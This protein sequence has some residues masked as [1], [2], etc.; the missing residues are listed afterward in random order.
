MTFL[1]KA[2]T[3]W[4][5]V[6][7]SNFNDIVLALHSDSISDKLY[8]GGSFKFYDQQI[9]KGVAFWNGNDVLN[10][11]C[12][13]GGCSSNRCGGVIQFEKYKN[14]LYALFSCK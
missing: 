14:E 3:R 12:G 10:L 1:C 4:N 11:N 2:Q 13:L 9:Y 8:I 7:N 6:S 5:S